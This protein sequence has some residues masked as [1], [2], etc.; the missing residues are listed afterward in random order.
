MAVR[1]IAKVV[2]AYV[3]DKRAKPMLRKD[4][5]FPYDARILSGDLDSQ[6][7]SV[8][9]VA[10]RRRM[11]FECGDGQRTRL[12]RQQRESDRI[13]TFGVAR[14]EGKRMPI[15]TLPR[16]SGRAAVKRPNVT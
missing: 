3:L 1:G 10:G 12:E 5:A 11:P 4:G 16:I 9:T 8:G 13:Y 2:C 15:A 14:A 7:V 6:S